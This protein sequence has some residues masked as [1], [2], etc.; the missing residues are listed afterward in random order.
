MIVPEA[1]SMKL[2]IELRR[3][4]TIHQVWGSEVE[5]KRQ[6]V[7][8]TSQRRYVHEFS[9]VTPAIEKDFHTAEWYN[10]DCSYGWF[11]IYSTYSVSFLFHRFT[12]LFWWGAVLKVYEV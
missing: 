4:Q 1:K 7:Q 9:T 5:K 11:C 12:R 8:I 6:Q 2:L 10:N 3:I